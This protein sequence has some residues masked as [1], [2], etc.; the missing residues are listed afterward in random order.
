MTLP[1]IT[2]FVSDPQL[3]NLSLSD[4]QATLLRTIYG[5]PLSSVQFDLFRACTGRQNAPAAGF[6][7]VTVIADVDAI[8]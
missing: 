7:E 3:L 2:E 5:L 1:D 4:A 6:G 8:S